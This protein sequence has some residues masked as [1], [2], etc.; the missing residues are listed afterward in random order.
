M[1]YHSKAP[2]T[3]HALTFT[4]DHQS[5]RLHIFHIENPF[6]LQD[7]QYI[8][9]F[10]CFHL[11]QHKDH[12]RD[13]DKVGSLVEYLS[14]YKYIIHH[15]ANPHGSP[16]PPVNPWLP[17]GQLPGLSP[18]LSPWLSPGLHRRLPP[19]LPPLLSPELTPV[20]SPE[21]SSGLP[22]PSFSPATSWVIPQTTLADI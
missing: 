3:Y 8:L 15:Q 17:P 2:S 20:L 9:G 21:Y 14:R 10:E 19:T 4:L 6:G 5:N 12:H 7:I 22:P 16:P 13:K 1:L 11:L 18:W